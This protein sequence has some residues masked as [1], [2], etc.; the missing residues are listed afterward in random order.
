M[1][2]RTL[3][4]DDLSGN[5]EAGIDRYKCYGWFT[6]HDASSIEHTHTLVFFNMEQDEKSVLAAPAQVQEN[7]TKNESLSEFKLVLALQT[8]RSSTY[9]GIAQ[10]RSSYSSAQRPRPSAPWASSTPLGFSSPT[11]RSIS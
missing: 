2:L 6:C 10:D 9:K 8:P 5:F 1:V 3:Q 7:E 11:I 4:T